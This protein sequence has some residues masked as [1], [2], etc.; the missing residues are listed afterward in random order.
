MSLPLTHADLVDHTGLIASIG[1][2]LP[3]PA[4]SRTEQVVLDIAWSDA[5]R[6]KAASGRIGR[7]LAFLF[8]SEAPLPLGSEKLEALRQYGMLL[9]RRG[10]HAV[11]ATATSALITAGYTSEQ[12]AALHMTFDAF[13]GGLVA[14]DRKGGR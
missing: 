14:A 7:V 2:L 4:F 9:R 8:G 11:P 5:H 12:I 1:A 3:T 6:A 13:S 10:S